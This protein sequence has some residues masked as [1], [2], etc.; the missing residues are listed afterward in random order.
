[1][2]VLTQA[3]KNICITALVKIGVISCRRAA[4]GGSFVI[5]MIHKVNHIFD[6]IGFS[7]YTVS[8]IDSLLLFDLRLSRDRSVL[9]T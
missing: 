4:G 5:L 2:S 3:I 1:M 7:I 9:F 6:T 8:L